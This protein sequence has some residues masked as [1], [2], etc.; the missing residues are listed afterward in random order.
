M[1]EYPKIIPISGIRPEDAFNGPMVRRLCIL[2]FQCPLCMEDHEAQ[3]YI[4]LPAADLDEYVA[5]LRP[6]A[7]DWKFIEPLLTREV[8]QFH[9]ELGDLDVLARR[10][11]A[12]GIGKTRAPTLELTDESDYTCDDCSRTFDSI[13]KL[14][15][16]MDNCT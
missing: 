3:M 6:K 7:T 5:N 4:S 16:H 9:E 12:Q 14:R 10:A 8:I 15:Q 1:E 11:G 13:Q 2:N